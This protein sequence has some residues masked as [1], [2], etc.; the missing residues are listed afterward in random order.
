MADIDRRLL[1]ALTTLMP[2]SRRAWGQALTVELSHTRRRRDRVQLVLAAARVTLLPPAGLGGYG[3]AG[4][5]AAL[6]A[7]AAC[8]PLTTALYLTNVV[9]PSRQDSTLGVLAMD[10]YL[11]ITLM[12][13]GALA[14]RTCGGRAAPAVA[15]IVAG[16]V[17]AVIGMSAFA[18]IDN[19]FLSVVSHQ[20]AK[21]AGFHAS[22]MT[23]MRAYL[24]A[25]LRATA[26][27]VALELAVVG[28]FLGSLGSAFTAPNLRPVR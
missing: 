17:I 5:R 10:A 16:L 14:R 27:G 11:A 22:G 12:L 6:L 3:R 9:F 25:S 26:P 13:A 8:I 18:V 2:P 19:A 28:A 21:L 15:G 7:A 24:N 23:S 4:A 1:A 20:Q